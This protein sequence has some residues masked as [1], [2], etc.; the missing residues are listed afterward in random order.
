[1]NWTPIIILIVVV[2]AFLWLK[3]RSQISSK[4]AIRYLKAGALVIDV[5]SAAEFNA[6]H[7]SMAINIPLDHLSEVAPR[8]LP[9]KED[10]LLLHCHSGMR[11]SMAKRRLQ[12][13]G[14]Q[15]VF[16]LGSYARAAQVT[17]VL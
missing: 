1:M 5:R 3:Q 10:V 11:S 13:L 4:D 17:R 15:N 9:R 12:T 7:L 6:G 14:Y 8:R 2:I 16:N